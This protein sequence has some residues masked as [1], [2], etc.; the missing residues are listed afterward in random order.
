MLKWSSG[1]SRTCTRSIDL[2]QVS[3]SVQ[4]LPDFEFKDGILV[5]ATSGFVVRRK[6][7]CV[8]LS[9]VDLELEDKA[10]LRRVPQH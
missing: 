4:D 1:I 3:F 8:R 10:R 9:W 2:T 7:E 5:W 6:D